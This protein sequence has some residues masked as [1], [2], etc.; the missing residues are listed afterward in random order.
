MQDNKDARLNYLRSR[1]LEADLKGASVAWRS[2]DDEIAWDYDKCIFCFTAFT[3]EDCPDTRQKGFHA[4]YVTQRG[5]PYWIC[6]LCFEDFKD[7]FHWTVSQGYDEI[8]PTQSNNSFNR[9][10][11]RMAFIIKRLFGR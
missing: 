8:N 11:D 3:V 4:G 7:L 9:T 6:E 1:N 10:L 5:T 2:A